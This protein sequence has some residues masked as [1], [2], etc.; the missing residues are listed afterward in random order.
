MLTVTS[1]SAGI[2]GSNMIVT[3]FSEACQPATF[4]EEPTLATVRFTASNR[5]SV[6]AFAIGLN[7]NV[8]WLSM[9]LSLKS[10]VTSIARCNTSTSRLGAYLRTDTDGSVGANELWRQ[11]SSP[12]SARPVVENRK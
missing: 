9:D 4:S 8:T 12:H 7:R 3:S 1:L 10:G 11:Y 6:R 2:G 5:N